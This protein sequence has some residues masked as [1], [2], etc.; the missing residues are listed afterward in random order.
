[1]TI[2][3]GLRRAVIQLSIVSALSMNRPLA[4]A[5]RREETLRGRHPRD[6]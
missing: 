1:M 4:L 5:I 3:A 6:S 2:P